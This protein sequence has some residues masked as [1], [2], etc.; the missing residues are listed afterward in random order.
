[1][2]ASKMVAASTRGANSGMTMTS[3]GSTGET[4]SSA[5]VP[6]IRGGRRQ[7]HIGLVLLEFKVG[8]SF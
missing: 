7:K 3:K 4:A 1:M 5:S 2:F 6:S 8:K